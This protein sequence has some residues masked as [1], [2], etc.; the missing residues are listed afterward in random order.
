T[1]AIER[2]AGLYHQEGLF[3]R[4][5]RA[6]ADLA[7][8]LFWQAPPVVFIAICMRA[9]RIA[10]RVR[11]TWSR[12]A[13]RVCVTAMLYGKG[14]YVAALRVARQATAQPLN[15]AWRWLLA[16]IVSSIN[17]QLG[18]PREALATIDEAMQLPQVEYDDR[19]RQ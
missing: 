18:R 17:C 19:L 9:V 15:P 13:T 14:R 16:M 4:E 6:L 1:T 5:L 10:D 3:Q 7:A 8:L 12:G 11:D 2:A